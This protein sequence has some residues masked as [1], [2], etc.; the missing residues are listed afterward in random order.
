[1]FL[2]DCILKCYLL[3]LESNHLITS[4][5]SQN[6]K[7][8][9][10]Q[11]ETFWIFTFATGTGI[12]PRNLCAEMV[13]RVATSVVNTTSR[14]REASFWIHVK[15]ENLCIFSEIPAPS[16]FFESSELEFVSFVLRKI[17]SMSWWH[18]FFSMIRF[19]SEVEA[20]RLC[21]HHLPY[22]LLFDFLATLD[23][24]WYPLLLGNGRLNSEFA[25]VV[26]GVSFVSCFMLRV[27]R[28]K[29]E[30]VRNTSLRFRF[31]E[32]TRSLILTEKGLFLTEV[33]FRFFAAEGNNTSASALPCPNRQDQF[34][35][36][37]NAFLSIPWCFVRLICGWK[38]GGSWNHH[39]KW[40][41]QNRTFRRVNSKKRY[42]SCRTILLLAAFQ[43]VG[44]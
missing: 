17:Q 41:F 27:S 5:H 4:S 28:H 9:N 42:S 34:F 25:A 29:S 10:Q 33:C 2:V 23:S 14:G 18:P 36:H 1:M 32:H 44:G 24:V 12:T 43:L 26:S 37:G 3:L 7:F 13:R 39:H 31:S 15:W 20:A 21:I 6:D 11:P 35:Q 40:L 16:I 38:K 19:D 22:G 8:D 30:A